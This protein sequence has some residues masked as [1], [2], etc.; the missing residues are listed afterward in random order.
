V[1]VVAIVVVVVIVVSV[2][3][4]LEEVERLEEMAERRPA[5]DVKLPT[6][7]KWIVE[8][9]KKGRDDQELAP[10]SWLLVFSL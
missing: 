5:A 1:K 7:G 4:E 10:L 8:T 2:S 6:I 3:V 9:K